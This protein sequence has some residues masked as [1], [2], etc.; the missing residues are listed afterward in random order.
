[1]RIAI[2]AFLVIA[3]VAPA[4]QGA[5]ILTQPLNPTV[6]GEFSNLGLTNQQIADNFQLAAQTLLD[7]FSWFGHYFADTAVA[8]PV[9]FSIRVFADD[10]GKPAVL[11]LQTINV[12]VNAVPTGLTFGTIPWFA[13][14]TPLAVVLNPGLYW[15]SVLET[16]PATPTIGGSQWMWGDSTTDGLRA[17]RS[18]DGVA[19]TANLDL[20]KA[21]S[22]TGTPVPEPSTLMMSLM[23]VAFAVSR[24]RRRRAVSESRRP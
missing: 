23:G 21:F 20:D 18:G 17:S 10:V 19:W 6:E 5:P 8:N 13:Y 22:L 15:I 12:S 4:A 9:D 11:P 16:D 2:A 14:S 1:M 7:S 24:A 3:G